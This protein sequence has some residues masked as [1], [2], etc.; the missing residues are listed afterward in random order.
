[1]TAA[2]LVTL[3]KMTGCNQID[4]GNQVSFVEA[5][6]LDPATGALSVNN[7]LIINQD[8]TVT[9]KDFITPVTPTLL[10]NAVGGIW[11]RSNALTVTLAGDANGCVNGDGGSIFGQFA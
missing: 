8:Q 1:L 4:F 6:I 3:Y 7:P 11:F 5:T 9:G 2:G 10:A